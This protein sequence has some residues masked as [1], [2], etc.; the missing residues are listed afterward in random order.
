[1]VNCAFYVASVI[2]VIVIWWKHMFD[3]N[4]S[5]IVKLRKAKSNFNFSFFLLNLFIHLNVIFSMQIKIQWK[6][7]KCHL[8][9]F[10]HLD[11]AWSRH[12]FENEIIINNCS[13]RIVA[14]VWNESR[15]K[16]NRWWSYLSGNSSHFVE[17]FKCSSNSIK[18]ISKYFWITKLTRK[19][20]GID[21]CNCEI[22]DLWN[23]INWISWFR[24]FEISILI[25]WEEIKF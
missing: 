10:K 21:V 1:M 2:C 11:N 20:T 23:I 19:E 12:N 16:Y 4:T 7:S 6:I 24:I 22:I 17:F 25:F 15:L 13:D 8:E 9:S 5:L 18:L 14:S 3:Y